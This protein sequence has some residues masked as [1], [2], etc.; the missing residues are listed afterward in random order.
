M[1]AIVGITAHA[2]AFLASVLLIGHENVA[3]HVWLVL[4]VLGVAFVVAFYC[5]ALN[6]HRAVAIAQ[7]LGFSL[8]LAA[9]F[10]GA[11]QALT[12]LGNSAKRR[13]QEP[14]F[15]GGLTLPMFLVAGPACVALGALAQA[16]LGARARSLRVPPSN[17][18][19]SAR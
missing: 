16:W 14:E 7:L 8:L 5:T 2:V 11:D 12:I 4:Y 6:L 13:A 1:Q 18:A 10:Y 3:P 15:L 17:S 9:M 19:G